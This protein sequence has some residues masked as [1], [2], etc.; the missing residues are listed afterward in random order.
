MYKFIAHR[1]NNDNNCENKFDCL[2][3]IVNYDYI[4]G[5]EV[6]VRESLDRVLVLNHNSFIKK[7]HSIYFIY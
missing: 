1:G 5:I 3:D 6:D 2:K 4:Y 7:N